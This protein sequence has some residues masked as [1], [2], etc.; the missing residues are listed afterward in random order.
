MNR[1]GVGGVVS[2]KTQHGFTLIELMVVVGI[3]GIVMAI[4]WP[5]YQQYLT[6]S[7]RATS[8]VADLGVST[9]TSV[10]NNYQ[11]ATITLVA[12]PPPTFT[13]TL[14][15][16]TPGPMSADGSLTIDNA[17]TKLRVITSGGTT[18]NESW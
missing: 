2:K 12:G 10:G 1:N 6:R 16:K 13:I 3:I 7:K 18:V 8:A 5:N 11:A 15:P 9:P 14:A 4:A 17:G